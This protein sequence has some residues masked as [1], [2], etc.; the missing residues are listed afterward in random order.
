MDE[1]QIEKLKTIKKTLQ[2]QQNQANRIYGRESQDRAKKLLGVPN[3]S[4]G[5]SS[6]EEFWNAPIRF[7]VKS[8]KQ[9]ADMFNKFAKAESQ[10]YDYAL[11]KNIEDKP[12]S[13]IA[14]QHGSYDGLFICKLTELNNI[15][16]KLLEMWNDKEEMKENGMD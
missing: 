1:E 9:V 5:V 15:V 16:D 2:T 3:R 4:V 7:E 11:E 8:G 10:S 14:M 13:M 6:D 12:F